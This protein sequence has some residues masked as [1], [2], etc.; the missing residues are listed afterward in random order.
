ME[1][2]GIVNG[3]SMEEWKDIK[4]YEGLY[5]VSNIGR[6]RRVKSGRVLIGFRCGGGYLY[7]IL[8][9][10]ETRKNYSVHRLVA[11]AFIPNPNNLP[12][13]NHKDED[14]TNNR[15]ENLEWC[16]NQYNCN[17]GTHNK[18]IGKAHINHLA[19]S[20]AVLCVETGVVFPS[21]S[22]VERFINRIGAQGNISACC[23]GKRKSAYGYHWEY[24]N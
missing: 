15:I 6:V 10:N 17:Y 18:R 7:V 2:C 16:T 23:L 22:E 19:L 11:Q 3:R 13:V 5:Q 4:G 21:A 12:Q 9:K 1:I 8:Y 24:A 14:K 20:K